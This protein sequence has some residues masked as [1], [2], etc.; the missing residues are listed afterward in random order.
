M[1]SSGI[2]V[3]QG[4]GCAAQDKTPTAT[5]ASESSAG[6]GGME[7]SNNQL[8]DASERGRGSGQKRQR[9]Q[10]HGR[11]PAVDFSKMA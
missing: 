11:A 4:R 2:K 6:I 3:Q 8:D 9:Q 10:Q 7:K 1:R 5:R